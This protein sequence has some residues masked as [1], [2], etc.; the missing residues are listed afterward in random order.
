MM[1]LKTLKNIIDMANSFLKYN[2]LLD[3][4]VLLIAITSIVVVFNSWGG[5][6][7]FFFYIAILYTAIFFF[8]HFLFMLFQ[9]FRYKK[10]KIW[11][12]ISYSIFL[13]LLSLFLKFIF[14][15]ILIWG[16]FIKEI[17]K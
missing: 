10:I 11:K 1:P 5:E 17:G 16:A 8:L 7:F 14:S 6:Y 9:L 12:T 13:V 15:T 4:V 3:I 2:F